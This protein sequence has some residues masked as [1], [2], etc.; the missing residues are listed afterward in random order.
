[1]SRKLYI[2]TGPSG[3]G[4]TTVAM[5]L[6]KRRPTLKKV[7]TCTTRKIREGEIDGVSYHFLNRE[8][9]Q[10]LIDEGGMFEWDEHY[11]NLYGS[12]R[13][14]VKALMEAGN[15]VL[16]VVD[17]AGAKTI[18]ETAPEAT[19]I[20]IEAESVN[21]LME[22]IAKRDKGTTA[23]LSQRRAAIEREMTFARSADHKVVNKED[24]LEETVDQIQALMDA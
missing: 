17:V 15:D 7:V 22:R 21:Q 11:E 18:K 23:G 4:K 3:V 14:D 8:T 13:S 24:K 1:M 12:R 6:L 9:F 16:F 10:Q 2:I 20:F 5:E 19:L